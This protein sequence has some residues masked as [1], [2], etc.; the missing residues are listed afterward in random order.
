MQEVG[1]VLEMIRR[2]FEGN[3]ILPIIFIVLLCF[4]KDFSK[5]QK[6]YILSIVI[7]LFLLFNPL[8]F[9]L[10]EKVGEE[11]TYYR[12][13]WMIPFGC[14]LAGGIIRVWES[15]QT[16]RQKLLFVGIVGVTVFLYTPNS[17]FDWSNASVSCM[18]EEV[19][20]LADVITEDAGEAE[21]SLF[22]NSDDVET[23]REY[24]AKILLVDDGPEDVFA[25]MFQHNLG[26][27]TG[28]NV[29]AV[30][31]NTG[32]EYVYVEKEK[33]ISQMA[34]M[35][36]GGM[37]AGETEH[38]Y[39][40]RFDLEGA[41]ELRSTI[42]GIEDGTPI[43]GIEYVTVPDVQEQIRFM[44]Y[45]DN[46]IALVDDE[47]MV[48]EIYLTDELEYQTEEFEEFVIC[49]IANGSGT[50]SAETIEQFIA[51]KKKEK[52][53]ILLLEAAIPDGKMELEETSNVNMKALQD[54][55]LKEDS[56]VVAIYASGYYKTYKSMLENGLMQCVC[57]PTE[58]DVRVVITVR[59]Q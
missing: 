47:L 57:I 53:I 29:N 14:I 16:K 1:S 6:K 20:A 26:N 46:H 9:K 5:K 40:Y 44:Y 31:A 23:I 21:V 11:E 36:G 12:L 22:L 10:M 51:L 32:I 37:F 52:P 45:G 17:L 34:L 49:A 58:S 25:F 48:Q 7:V 8:V 54:E 3:L 27:I 33:N 39:V 19:I 59:G 35:S 28:E 55:I 38:Y 42:W 18:P 15:F 2:Y 50:V 30:I 13:I 56:S 43:G 24:N 4:I 41:R